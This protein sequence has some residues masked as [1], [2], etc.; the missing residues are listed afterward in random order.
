MILGNPALEKELEALRSKNPLKLQ[1]NELWHV[2]GL[3]HE[4]KAF[5]RVTKGK[6]GP[7]AWSQGE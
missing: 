5:M 1:A 4:S 3:G 6:N 2:S 7:E